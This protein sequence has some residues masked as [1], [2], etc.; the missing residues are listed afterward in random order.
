[1]CVCVYLFCCW[2]AVGV[3]KETLCSSGRRSSKQIIQVYNNEWNNATVFTLGMKDATH[4][5]SLPQ[6]CVGVAVLWRTT[7]RGRHT[8]SLFI[9]KHFHTHRLPSDPLKYIQDVQRW[10]KGYNSVALCYVSLC[11]SS[12]VCFVRSTGFYLR[13]AT[14]CLW[15]TGHMTSCFGGWLQQTAKLRVLTWRTYN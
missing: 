6:A 1:M 9:T 10:M 15:C 5:T 13:R 8:P 2:S 12:T 3:L 4:C 11:C 14:S 7:T